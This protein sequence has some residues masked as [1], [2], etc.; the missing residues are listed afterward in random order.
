MLDVSGELIRYVAGLLSAECRARGTRKGTRALS[1][2]IQAVFVI[3]WFRDRPDIARHGK[4]FV[5][6]QAIC[7]LVLARGDRRARRPGARPA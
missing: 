4:A 1:C 3:A 6:R 2:W 7:L 5:I